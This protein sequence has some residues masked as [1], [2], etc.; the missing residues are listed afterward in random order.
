MVCHID[1]SLNEAFVESPA[2]PTLSKQGSE[3]G[4]PMAVFVAKFDYNPETDSPN[5]NPNSELAI[6]AGEYIYVYGDVDDV[7]HDFGSMYP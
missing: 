4:S 7:N 5:D 3:V 6:T 2:S 1:L